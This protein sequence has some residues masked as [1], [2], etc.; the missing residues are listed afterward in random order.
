MF[1][2]IGVVLLLAAGTGARQMDVG[3]VVLVNSLAPDY[4][5][6]SGILEP[7]LV[8]FG[9]P[10]SVRDVSQP[11]AFVGLDDCSLVIV[12]HR[13]LDAPRRF[14]TSEHEASLVAAIKHGTG[15]VSFDGLLAKWEGKDAEPIYSYPRDILGLLYGKA[16][17]AS[18]IAIGLDGAHYI[19]N[20]RAVP[21][22]VKLKA[23]MHVPGLRPG[24]GV[25]VVARAGDAPLVLATQLGEGR[26]VLFA[27]YDWV[28]PEIKGRFYGLDDLVWRALVWAARKP[29]VIRGMP[30]FLAL[31]VDDVSGFGIGANQHLGWIETANRYGL[32]PWVGVFID[33][34]REDPVAVRRLANLT[35]HGLATASVHARRWRKFFYLDE[36]LATDDLNRN[37]AATPWSAEKMAANWAE[38]ERFFKENGIVKSRLILPHFYEFAPNNFDGLNHWGADLVGTVLEPGQGYGTRMPNAG[39]YLT[40]E[41][42]SSNGAD[43]IFIADWLKVPGHPEFNHQFFNF[44][45]EVRDVTGYEWAPSGVP[46]EEAI[47]RGVEESRREFD[48]QLPAVLFT[49]ESDHIQHLTPEA[50]ERILAGVMRELKED[51]PIPVTLDF[52]G[53]YLRA[54]HTSHIRSARY[55]PATREG[56]VEITGTSDIATEL[57]V[58]EDDT[59]SPRVLEAPATGRV[60]EVRWAAATLPGAR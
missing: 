46:V 34:L 41:T 23:P 54:L 25:R 11:N 36:P 35:Q 1:R 6:F 4:S 43:P 59:K 37:I 19:A 56:V 40:N 28:R 39:P 48:S 47:R 42:R 12:G 14:I 26:A 29:F 20:Q 57:F 52:V 17:E 27:S 33:D 49:H 60:S 9:I 3:A 7:Y 18:E 22:T 13:G 16:G 58:F 55:D 53:Q 31:R 5:D 38:A 10:Y 51:A 30:K 21:R 24:E 2:A 45:A 50:W 44:I 32:K 8:H 15:L